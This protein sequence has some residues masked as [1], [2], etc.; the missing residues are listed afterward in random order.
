MTFKKGQS[1]CIGGNGGPNKRKQIQ[2]LLLP[3][4]PDAIQAMISGLKDPDQRIQA[5]KDILDRVYG[6]ALQQT[7]LSGELDMNINV[8][9]GMHGDKSQSLATPIPSV[10]IQSN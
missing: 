5:A 1:G 4:V 9:V 2:E 3:H 6:K 8:N 10:Y 7:E